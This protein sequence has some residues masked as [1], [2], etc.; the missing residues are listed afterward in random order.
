MEKLIAQDVY[1]RE[2]DTVQQNTLRDIFTYISKFNIKAPS[3]IVFELQ[4][5][6]DKEK[7]NKS[8]AGPYRI[9]TGVYQNFNN[10][11]KENLQR[12]FNKC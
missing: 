1:L 11:N 7:K 12:N 6:M 2:T 4:E 3:F 10:T 8:V 5:G 9:S